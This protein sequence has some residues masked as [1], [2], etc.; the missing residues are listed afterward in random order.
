M[1]EFGLRLCRM[2]ADPASACPCCP[3]LLKQLDVAQQQHMPTASVV[4]QTAQLA[5]QSSRREGHSQEEGPVR[6]RGLFSVIWWGHGEACSSGVL[7][8]AGSM[9]AAGVKSIVLCLS[10]IAGD[11]WSNVADAHSMLVSRHRAEN[12][13]S[14]ELATC[15]QMTLSV[16]KRKCWSSVSSSS[17]QPWFPPTLTSLSMGFS[18]R[19]RWLL[20]S[21]LHRGSSRPRD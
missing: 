21:L 12:L 7:W 5:L 6:G 2:Q 13:L 4:S 8:A 9:S 17:L 15:P 18:G 19:R 3:E 20:F 16:C 10:S 14:R 11:M 1:R